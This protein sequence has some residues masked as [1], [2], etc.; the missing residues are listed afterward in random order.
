MDLEVSLRDTE[1][2][3]GLEWRLPSL[4]EHFKGGLIKGD[5][6]LFAGPVGKGKTSFLCDQVGYMAQQLKDD[7]YVAWFN[8]EG[9]WKR[10]NNRLYSSVLEC[11]RQTL[12][13]RTK[14]AIL[15]YT[16]KMNGNKNRVQVIDYQRK[17]TRDIENRLK[18]YPPSLIVFDLLDHVRGFETLIKAEGGLTERYN[19]LYQWAL[20][21]AN[22]Y[23]PVIGA[24]Q[25]NGA[26]ANEPYPT[27][28]NLRG[29]QVDK[30]AAATA[31]IILGGLDG[32]MSTRYLSTPKNKISGDE[33]WR[34][35]VKFDYLRSRFKD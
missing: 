24:S 7:Q 32:D 5:F 30:Q 25:L 23:A 4:Q 34:K 1:R 3:G 12:T 14:E 15:R 20:E 2:K 28:N 29:S 13:N 17:N 33:S 8:F 11:T 16:E 19:Q 9:D 22:E 27:M 6:I 26:G 10:V 31:M 21:I 18:K 35:E